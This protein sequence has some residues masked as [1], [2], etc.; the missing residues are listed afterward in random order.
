MPLRKSA[1]QKIANKAVRKAG[2]RKIPG[3]RNRFSATKAVR[4][5]K[6][7]K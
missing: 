6:K 7:G 2:G 1:A 3:G 5:M 4:T